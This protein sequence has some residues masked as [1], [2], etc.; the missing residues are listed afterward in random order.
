MLKLQGENIYLATLEKEHCQK[1]WESFEYDADALTEPLNIGHSSVKADDWFDEIQR[2]QGNKN[3]RLGIFLLNNEVIGDVALQDIDW[4]NR[5]CSVGIGIQQIKHRSHGYGS[6]AVRL[7]LEHGFNNLGL[8]RIWANTLESNIG[9]Q[10][11]LEKVGFKNEGR[12][13]EA[14]Y[15]AGRYFDKLH[16]GLLREEYNKKD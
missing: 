9:A 7:M 3:V 15:F 10:R 12:S 14:E 13:R 2:L 8:H 11:A 1:L 6:E 4:R 5:S 16:Y